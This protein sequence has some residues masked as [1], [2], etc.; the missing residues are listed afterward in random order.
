MLFIGPLDYLSL[1]DYNK[2]VEGKKDCELKSRTIYHRALSFVS[3]KRYDDAKFD[4]RSILLKDPN[5]VPPRVL[6]SKAYKFTGHFVQSEEC[7]NQCITKD[8]VQ[9]EL[10][11]ERSYV[12]CRLGSNHNLKEAY[13]GQYLIIPHIVYICDLT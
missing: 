9:A 3:L 12:R 8:C 5:A 2:I 10:F 11:I 13:K 7:L 4:L 1:S 6:L